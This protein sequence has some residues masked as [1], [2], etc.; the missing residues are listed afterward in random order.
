MSK[1]RSLAFPPR[2]R[3][4]RLVT[5]RGDFAVLD[6]EP[7]GVRRGTVLLLPGY[8]GSKEDFLALL[9]PLGEAGYRAVAVDGRGQYETPGPRG[10]A[11][12]R[13]GALAL[14]VVAQAAA[15]GDGPVH[16]LGHSFGGLVA[17]A[18]ASLA[19][20]AFRSLTLLSSGPGRVARPQRVRVRVLRTALAVLPK[21]RVWEAM[22]RLDSRGEQPEADDAPQLA[23]FLRRRWTRTR[24]VQLAGAGRLLLS[25]EDGTAELTALPMPIHVAYGADEA[26][27]PTAALAATAARTGAH[28]TVVAGAGHS[29]NVSHPRELAERLTLFWE[30]AAATRTAGTFG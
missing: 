6:A 8:T 3:A 10:R 12:Y 9:G 7:V 23:D 4:R 5:A 17:R 30:R 13:R 1:P 25:R 20:D 14:D 11:A 2:T 26:V 27:W 19:P 22:C 24:I 29:P 16:L 15:L 21:D 18:A 28:H